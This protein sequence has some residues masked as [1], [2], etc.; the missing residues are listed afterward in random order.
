[1]SFPVS[2]TNGQVTVVN[3]VSYQYSSGGHVSEGWEQ[4]YIKEGL[5]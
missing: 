3:Q 4:I 2:P 5:E 1:M